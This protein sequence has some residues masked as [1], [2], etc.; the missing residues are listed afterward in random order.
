MLAQPLSPGGD[1]EVKSIA[2]P[3][4]GTPLRTASHEWAGHGVL[5]CGQCGEF[6]DFTVRTD[7]DTGPG[8]A[9]PR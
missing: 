4:C 2:C 8:K 7:E 5:E 3:Y 6:P 9:P 1:S